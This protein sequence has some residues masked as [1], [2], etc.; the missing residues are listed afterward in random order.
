MPGPLQSKPGAFR[1]WEVYISTDK[2]VL[3]WKR[4][5]NGFDTFGESGVACRGPRNPRKKTGKNTTANNQLALA[6]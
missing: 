5:R 4:G 1:S 3:R 6:A 2:S